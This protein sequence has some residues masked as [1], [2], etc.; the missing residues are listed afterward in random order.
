MTCMFLDM[1]TKQN[2]DLETLDA[3]ET[4]NFLYAREFNSNAA[5]TALALGRK[6]N[7]I[8][9]IPNG[10]ATIDEDL[11]MKIH[12]LAQQRYAEPLS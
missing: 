10:N 7:D 11:S 2:V 4:L 8:E 9:D 1:E 6:A 12:A 3:L 5:E